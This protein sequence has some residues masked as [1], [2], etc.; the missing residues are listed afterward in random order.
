MLDVK[1]GSRFTEF[2]MIGVFTSAIIPFALVATLV[3]FN[4]DPLWY[5]LPETEIFAIHSILWVLRL[6]ACSL[7]AY[8]GWINLATVFMVAILELKIFK[9]TKCKCNAKCQGKWALNQCYMVSTKNA[10]KLQ[11]LAQPLGL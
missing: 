9:E 8:G 11:F 2:A 6:S 3:I 10:A 4:C 5:I 1:R 7:A